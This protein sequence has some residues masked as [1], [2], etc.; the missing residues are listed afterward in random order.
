MENEVRILEI[1]VEKW[2]SM[3]EE[4]GAKKVGEWTQI[5]NVYDF[6]PIQKNKWIRLRTNGEQTT[7]TIKEILDHTKLDGVR[8]LDIEVSDFSKTAEILEELGYQARAVQENKRIRYIYQDI[9]IDIDS[10]PMIPTYVEIEGKSVEDVQAFLKQISY[11]ENKLTT[12]DVE[13]VYQTIY[14]IHI[15]DYPILTFETKKK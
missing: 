10:W 13:S 6:H 14:G 7:L 3:L 11:D 15:N 5:R 2:L 1:D 12:L 8:E 9:E 4:M